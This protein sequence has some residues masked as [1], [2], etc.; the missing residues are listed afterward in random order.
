MKEYKIHRI[1]VS[2]LLIQYEA[3]PS[4]EFLRYLL[5]IKESLQ[6]LFSIEVIHTYTELLLKFRRPIDQ[7]NRLKFEIENVLKEMPQEKIIKNMIHHIPVCYEAPFSKDLLEVSNIL[8]LSKEETIALHTS[9]TYTIYFI[10]FLPGFL[11]LDGLATALHIPRKSTPELVVPKGSV[12]IGGA[13]TG[14]YPQTSPGGWHILGH[15]PISFFNTLKE[16][17]TP[18]NPGDKLQFYTITTEE[19]QYISRTITEGTYKHRKE[20]IYGE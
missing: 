3:N 2:T 9:S 19:H 12:A 20:S 16:W 8:G 6:S 7:Y 4:D 15:T 11:Y 18:F 1:N 14:I 13:Q 10:G 5:S 17:E